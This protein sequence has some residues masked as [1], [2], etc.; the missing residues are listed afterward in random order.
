MDQSE[1]VPLPS[2]QRLYLGVVPDDFDPQMDLVV[3]PWSLLENP[4]FAASL[5]KGEFEDVYP[6]SSVLAADAERIAVLANALTADMMQSFNSRHGTDYGAAYWRILLLPW[7]LWMCQAVWVRF[8]YVD[9]F[10]EKHRQRQISVSVVGGDR[11]W[12][13]KDMFGLHQ[14]V[15]QTA[16]F[17]EWLSARVLVR[18]APAHW[19]ISSTATRTAPPVAPVDAPPTWFRTMLRRFRATFADQRCRRVYGITW[20]SLLISAYLELLPSRPQTI[21][22]DP[23]QDKSEIAAEF[24]SAFIELIDDI[25]WRTTPDVLT[26]D[27][28]DYDRKAAARRYRPGKINLIGPLLILSE[29]EKFI[30]AH[31]AEHGERIVCTQHGSSG[32]QRVNINSVEIENRQDAYISWGWREQEDYP[33]TIVPLPSP[34]YSKYLDT[35]RPRI[36]TLLYVATG[37]RIYGHRLETSFQP[38]QAAT[39]VSSIKKFFSSIPAP[40][41]KKSAYRAYPGDKG[42]V[43]TVTPIREAFPDLRMHTGALHRDLRRTRLTVIDHYG[44][45][46]GIAMVSNAPTILIW[47]RDIWDISRQA[48]DVFADLCKAGIAQPDHE[49]A[50]RLATEIWNDVENWWQSDIVQTARLNFC[51]QYAMTDRC[52]LRHWLSALR[53]I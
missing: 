25:L 29:R 51:E 15:L 1:D 2:T 45:T 6:N 11:D 41:R 12:P 34:Y 36:P 44:T 17:N 19:G 14:N 49:S 7:V 43:D 46:F 22:I 10:V 37:A 8:R 23:T 4:E 31:A 52:W 3:G 40:L 21:S 38:M 18:L 50:A 35:A 39:Y 48:E 42:V 33:G 30:L 47:S 16:E 5:S 20:Q 13:C 32:Y 26:R 27:F 28:A 9:A 53:T 24:P